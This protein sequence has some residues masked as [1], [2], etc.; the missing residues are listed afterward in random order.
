VLSRLS[1]LYQ[2]SFFFS[3]HSWFLNTCFWRWVCCKL[4]NYCHCSSWI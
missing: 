4:L 3:W 1:S 2:V